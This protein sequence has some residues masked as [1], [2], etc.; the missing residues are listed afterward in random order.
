MVEHCSTR[1]ER[2]VPKTLDGTPEFK[3][4]KKAFIDIVLDVSH[5]ACSKLNGITLE[6]IPLAQGIAEMGIDVNR[7]FQPAT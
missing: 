1:D 6:R 7:K 2:G 5:L 4:D 3:G